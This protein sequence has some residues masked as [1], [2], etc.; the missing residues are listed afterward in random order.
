MPKIL[1]SVR[2]QLLETARAQVAEKGYEKTTIR[3][4][5]SECGI[6]VGTVYNYFP[7]KDMLIASYVA[8]DW[9]EY[10]ERMNGFSTDDPESFFR[11]IYDSLNEFSERNRSLFSD[12][13]AAKVFSASFP[14][15]HGILRDQLANIIL[16]FCGKD[17][18]AGFTA[19]F[20]AESL[21]TWTM[22]KAPFSQIYS[23]I[24][25]IIN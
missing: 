18:D 11:N 1:E 13:D 6:A 5:A 12:R 14:Q 10:L 4:V 24:K 8:D 22:A 7:S 9:R 25:K 17:G 15:R 23:I 21:L 3:S 19:Q 20:T 2:E 16:P